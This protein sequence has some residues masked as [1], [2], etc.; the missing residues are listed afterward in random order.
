MRTCMRTYAL[1]KY[2]SSIMNETEYGDLNPIL[3][4]VA[5]LT[6][7]SLCC[8]QLT[9]FYIGLNKAQSLKERGTRERKRVSESERERRKGRARARGIWRGKERKREEKRKGG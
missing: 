1:Y 4:D 8:L 3:H 9:L 7:Y 5:W 6:L 2:L